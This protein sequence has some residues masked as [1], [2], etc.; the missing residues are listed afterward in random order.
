MQSEYNDPREDDPTQQAITIALI[1][2]DPDDVYLVKDLLS[3]DPRRVFDLH[4]FGSLQAFSDSTGGHYDLILLDLG[5]P[6]GQ[7]L[8]TLEKVLS[9]SLDAPIVVFTG[10]ASALIGEQA[11]AMGAQDYLVKGRITTELLT[12]SITYAIERDHMMKQRSAALQ[13]DP[14]TKLPNANVL[15]ERLSFLISQHPRT[16]IPFTL[17]FIGITNLAHVERYW[18][19]EVTASALERVAARL[20]YNQRAADSTTYMGQEM[21]CLVLLGCESESD[22]MQVLSKKMQALAEPYIMDLDKPAQ[23]VSLHFAAGACQFDDGQSAEKLLTRTREAYI[24]ASERPQ[25][26]NIAIAGQA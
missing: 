4:T 17:V 19:P 2:D 23:E 25:D 26:H 24:R 12:K 5:L 8:D 9:F 3:W 16:R 22:V 15:Y 11:I 7:K 6:D 21:Y 10:A 20:I 13:I 14:V 18:G 1:E